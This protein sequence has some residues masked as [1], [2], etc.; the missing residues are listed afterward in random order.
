MAKKPA[1]ATKPKKE[2][3]AT[4]KEKPA[5]KAK[6]TAQEKKAAYSCDVVYGTTAEFG[7]DYLRDN[8]KTRAEE[9]LQKRRE[10]AVVDEVDSI[11][12]DEARTPLIISGPAHATL[13]R[14]DIADRVARH[15]VARQNEWGAAD[16]A[17]QRSKEKVAGLEGDIRNARDRGTIPGMKSEMDQERANLRQLEVKRDRFTQFYE[18]ELDKKQSQLTHDGIAEAQKAA[19]VGSFYVGDNIDLPHL[20]EQS[21]R[22]H[23]V[24]QRDRDYVVAPDENGQLGV[25][26]VDQNTGR[27]MVGRQWSDGLHQAVEAKEG[28]RIKEETQT[29]ATITIQNYFKL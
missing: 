12:I 16:D 23:V 20:V 24:Y 8:M 11:L 18:L 13:P 15:L 3:K 14:Y 26:I 19:G 4:K 5:K 1:E 17:V 29:M 22:A 25:V 6:M 7:F 9:Q 28:V 10:F 2:A 27:K 21:L